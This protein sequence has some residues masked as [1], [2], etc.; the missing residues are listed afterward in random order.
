MVE[1]EAASEGCDVTSSN[2]FG[3]LQ[4]PRT[5]L[6]VHTVNTVNTVV[7]HTCMCTAAGV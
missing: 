7:V 1:V 6:S 4:T 3:V 5:R 2:S